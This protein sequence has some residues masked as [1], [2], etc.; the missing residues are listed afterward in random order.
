MDYLANLV[1]QEHKLGKPKV[2]VSLM[3]DEMSIKKHIYFNN[4]KFTGLVDLGEDLPSRP[5]DNRPA[6]HALV[7]MANAV[8]GHWKIP[9]AYYMI[10][11]LNA[12]GEYFYICE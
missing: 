11:S 7:L 12:Q 4:S 5:L 2:L 10:D 6:T 8:N 9:I 3:I 1:S